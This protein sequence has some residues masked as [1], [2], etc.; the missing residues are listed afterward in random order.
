[1]KIALKVLLMVAI[2][3]YAAIAIFRFREPPEEALC[4]GVDITVDNKDSMIIVSEQFV[5]DILDEN[6]IQ[7]KGLPLKETNLDSLRTLLEKSPYISQALC[8]YNANSHL[9]IDVKPLR[10]IL[11]VMDDKGRSYYT[12]T[13]GVFM[14]VGDINLDVCIATGHVQKSTIKEKLIPLVWYISQDEFW[15]DEV[16]QIDVAKNDEITLIPRHGEHRMLL[17]SIDRFEE[18]LANMRLFYEKGF[19]QVGWNK[20]ELIDL[21]FKGQVVAKKAKKKK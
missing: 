15:S 9:C 19:P 18:K 17:G 7:P 3:V 20:Y 16:M 8:N 12:D 2:V 14:P 10:P 5:Q 21:R 1:M 6:Q 4:E 11:H 13:T